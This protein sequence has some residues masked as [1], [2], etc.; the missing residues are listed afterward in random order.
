[1]AAQ[2]LE[3]V[4]QDPRDLHLREPDALGDL[5]LGQAIDETQPEDRLLA[6][7]EL[8]QRVREPRP[9][10]DSRELRVRTPQ[11]RATAARRVRV[12]FLERH[13]V[14]RD[15][16]GQRLKYRLDADAGLLGEL[17]GG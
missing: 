7:T 2:Q 10:L 15:A 12:G 17:C 9:L 5:G 13:R 3:R 1:M 11:C 6:G 14:V 4:A 8:T 16:S